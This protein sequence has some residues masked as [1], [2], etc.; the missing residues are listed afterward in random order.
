M[1]TPGK[2]FV[3]TKN[4]LRLTLLIVNLCMF[5]NRFYNKLHLFQ[6][7]KSFSPIVIVLLPPELVISNAWA[8]IGCISIDM[9]VN[10]VK[11]HLYYLFSKFGPQ[12]NIFVIS[13]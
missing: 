3:G 9:H 1:A 11:G 2:D 8:I 5:F 7:I 6:E 4:H 12:T 10:R 13:R